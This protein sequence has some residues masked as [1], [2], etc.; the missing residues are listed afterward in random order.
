MEPRRK[1][2]WPL[3]GGVF[4]AGVATVSFRV[5]ALCR[6]R[7]PGRNPKGQAARDLR[8]PADPPS[9]PLGATSNNPG[10]LDWDWLR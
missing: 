4:G 2:E 3:L 8:P 1:N 6:R 10:E 9:T 7:G 5:H